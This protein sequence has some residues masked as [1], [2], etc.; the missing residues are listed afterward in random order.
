MDAAKKLTTAG[1]PFGSTVATLSPRPIPKPA[2]ASAIAVTCWRSDSYETRIAESVSRIA[3]LPAGAV[4]I[5]S[6]RVFGWGIGTIL[7]EK[8][9]HQMSLELR[10]RQSCLQAALRQERCSH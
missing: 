8:L 6:R 1:N 4:S 3:V 9:C 10:G 7:A 2:S 5:S